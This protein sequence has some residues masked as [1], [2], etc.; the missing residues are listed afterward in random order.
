MSITLRELNPRLIRGT[1][2]Y[3]RFDLLRSDPLEEV[4]GSGARL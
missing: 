3:E 1:E 4:V 2:R